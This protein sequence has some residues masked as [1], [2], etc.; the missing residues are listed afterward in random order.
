MEDVLVPLFSY[1][2]YS[3]ASL[4]GIALSNLRVYYPLRSP[5][6]QLLDNID[7]LSI[8]ICLGLISFAMI[9]DGKRIDRR[10]FSLNLIGQIPTQ[11]GNY[12]IQSDL[13]H[14]MCSA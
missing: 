11:N 6:Y 10:A 9:M 8:E 13:T 2:T 3:Q 5:Y 1:L 14:I 7:N 4:T 12:K